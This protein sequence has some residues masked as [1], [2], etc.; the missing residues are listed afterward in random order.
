[1]RST[2]IS[3]LKASLSACLDIVK[4]GED[5]LVTD[6]GRA[7]AKIIPVTGTGLAMPPH[8]AALR[9]A[10]LLAP[11]TGTLPATFWALPRPADTSGSA[12]AA[13]AADREAP[14]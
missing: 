7:V 10:G 4:S 6:R 8:L 9:D 14:R 13:L 5:I 1:M 12:L 11:G 2:S 3:R